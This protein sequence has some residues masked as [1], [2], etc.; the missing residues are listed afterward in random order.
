MRAKEGSANITESHSSTATRSKRAAAVITREQ[1][2][3]EQR[4]QRLNQQRGQTQIQTA[5]VDQDSRVAQR[6]QN[7]LASKAAH[8]DDGQLRAQR[9]KRAAPLL[10]VTLRLVRRRLPRRRDKP[11]AMCQTFGM[12]KGCGARTNG[13]IIQRSHLLEISKRCILVSLENAESLV[14]SAYARPLNMSA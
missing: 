3:G 2:D 12:Q 10:Q 8:A 7:C 9:A 14:S 11:D 1:S 6:Y 5:T 4:G 13:L